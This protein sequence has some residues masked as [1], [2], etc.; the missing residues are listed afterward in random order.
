M[1]FTSLI[2]LFVLFSVTGF[3]Q[4]KT[5][6]TV[7]KGK[8]F[9]YWGWN[10]DGFSKSDINFKGPDYHF[11]LKNVVAY[12]QQEKFKFKTYFNPSIL[13]IP[14]Y[15]V[16]AGYFFKNNYSVSFGTDHM[17]YVVQPFQTV[18]ITGEIKGTG[19]VYDKVYNDEAIEIKKEFLQFEHTDGLNY[20]NFDVRRF[21][22]VLQFKKISINLSEGVG[23]GALLPRTNSILFNQERNDE[24]HLAGYGIN[25]LVALN[26]TF[27]NHF[28]LQ[29]ELK[30]GFI[31]MPDIRTTNS[32]LDKA[33]QHFFFTQANLVV[34][35]IFRFNNNQK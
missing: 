13:T 30:G 31:N 20:I 6:P 1:K 22:E 35:Y 33:S 3:A 29:S 7:N 17:K 12:D 15:N 2:F 11:T 19:T 25:G 14:Q 34:G 24:F 16:R 4:S 23:L 32:P 21:D 28:F 27:F 8:F 5:K 18:K 26:I 10:R 9:V